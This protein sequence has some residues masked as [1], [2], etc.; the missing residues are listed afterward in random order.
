V[1][2]VDIL[3]IVRLNKIVALLRQDDVRRS[4]NA[5]ELLA[6]DDT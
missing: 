1:M 4:Q 5:A 6:A 2:G 3:G